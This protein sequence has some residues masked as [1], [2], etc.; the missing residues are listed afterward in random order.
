MPTVVFYDGTCGLCDRFV[1]FLVRRDRSE[2]LR[3][4]PLQGELA[5]RTLKPQG[6]DPSDLDTVYVAADWGTDAERVLR[7]AEAVWHAL[8]QLGGGW[9]MIA[10][11]GRVL[12]KPLA[13]RFY[14]LVARNRYRV[15]GRFDAC[16]LPPPEWRERFLRASE[17]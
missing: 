16:P 6:Y 3:F 4:A 14:D 7:R 12:P 13:D 15:F 10:A 5:A 8:G 1:R 11:A 9:R 2:R 17:E